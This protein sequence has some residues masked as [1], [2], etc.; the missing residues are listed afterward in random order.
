M[1][2]EVEDQVEQPLNLVVCTTE[3][4]NNMKKLLRKILATVSTIRSLFVKLKDCSEKKTSEIN[5][6]TKQVDKLETEL[7]QRKDKQAKMHQMPSLPG[8]TALAEAAVKE[9]GMPS[10]ATS[11]EPIE[12]ALRHVAPPTD[13]TSRSYAAAVRGKEATA[14]KM[15]FRTRGEHSPDSNNC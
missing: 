14:F 6:L 7:N 9:H 2:D 10:T 13:K 5:N 4:S 1:A 15:T 3:K 8:A 11:P 12:L